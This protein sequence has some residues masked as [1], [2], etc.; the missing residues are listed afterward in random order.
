MEDSPDDYPGLCGTDFPLPP[1]KRIDQPLKV[2]FGGIPF[3][4]SLEAS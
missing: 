3:S 1:R 4:R 2:E